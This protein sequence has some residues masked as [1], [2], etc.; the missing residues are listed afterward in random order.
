[1]RSKP[2][3]SFEC[4]LVALSFCA[5]GSR[6]G[7]LG[8]YDPN[9]ILQVRNALFDM[10]GGRVALRRAQTEGGDHPFLIARVGINRAVLLA[11]AGSAS[12]CVISG[13]GGRI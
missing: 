11:A 8:L 5:N 7:N 12:G 3:A 9:S 13:S 6:E 1:M 4:F 10:F 2:P